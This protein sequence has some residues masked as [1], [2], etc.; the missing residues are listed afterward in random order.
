MKNLTLFSLCA[1]LVLLAC[2]KQQNEPAQGVQIAITLIDSAGNLLF[3]I[4]SPYSY[5]TPFDPTKS[6]WI[7]GKGKKEIFS[8]NVNFSSS[9]DGLIFAMRKEESEVKNDTNWQLN[10]MLRWQIF[11]NPD[12][13]PLSLII[14]Q[15]DFRHSSPD[16]III[17]NDTF[18]LKSLNT[19]SIQLVYP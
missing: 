1:L 7:D 17:K 3:P 13:A 10:R 19:N 11:F 8:Q 6:F 14:Y 5:T 2:K 15:P 4:S 16:Y 18:P 12:L 9:R